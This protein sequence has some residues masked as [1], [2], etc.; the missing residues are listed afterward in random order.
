MIGIFFIIIVGGIWLYLSGD[1]SELT[2]LEV[3]DEKVEG[4]KDVNISKT[5]K[6]LKEIENSNAPKLNGRVVIGEAM[7]PLDEWPE[8]I[9]YINKV[10]PNW[11]QKTTAHLNE[12]STYDR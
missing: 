12:A 10:D 2:D 1:E 7:K 8:K 3:D 11:D 5:E 9:N 6:G 4:K